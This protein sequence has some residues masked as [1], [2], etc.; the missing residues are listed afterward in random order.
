MPTKSS[1]QVKTCLLLLL[2]Q[3]CMEK[4]K[5]RKA[6]SPLKS[7]LTLYKKVMIGRVQQLLQASHSNFENNRSSFKLC[8]KKAF[9]KCDV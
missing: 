5:K 9:S 2:H 4:Y 3:T 8:R 6:T 1:S 7:D